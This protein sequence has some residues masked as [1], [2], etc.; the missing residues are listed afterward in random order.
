MHRQNAPGTG[1]TSLIAKSPQHGLL[2]ET[3][4]QRN[5]VMDRGVMTF[6]PDARTPG[7]ARVVVVF[8]PGARER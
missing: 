5:T 2:R 1:A 8:A 3:G 7:K 4:L 6:A